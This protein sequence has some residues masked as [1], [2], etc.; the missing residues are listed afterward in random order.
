MIVFWTFAKGL[1]ISVRNEI[2]SLPLYHIWKSLYQWNL[3]TLQKLF[4]GTTWLWHTDVLFSKNIERSKRCELVGISPVKIR[5]NRIS[6][7]VGILILVQTQ[8]ENIFWRQILRNFWDYYFFCMGL[9]DTLNCTGNGKHLL[10]T[11]SVQQILANVSPSGIYFYIYC[12]NYYFSFCT[13]TV[14]CRTKTGKWVCTVRDR[15]GTKTE[16]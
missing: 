9:K 16:Q 15:P 11:V 13:R 7:V 10:E 3:P 5:C 4:W 8:M 12:E 6:R 1:T 14:T 2:T